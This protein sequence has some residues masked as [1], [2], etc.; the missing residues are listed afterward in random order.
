VTQ[1]PKLTFITFFELNS[2]VS[3]TT[4]FPRKKLRPERGRGKRDSF[5]GPGLEK[6]AQK[7][8]KKFFYWD[9]FDC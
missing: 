4:V 1:N 6:V 8:R 2:Q 5:M 7:S 3:I 9:F